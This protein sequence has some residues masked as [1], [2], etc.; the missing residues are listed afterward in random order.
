MKKST[1]CLLVMR[2]QRNK[3]DTLVAVETL[4]KD[5][6]KF[7]DTSFHWRHDVGLATAHLASGTVMFHSCRH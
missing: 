2:R 6:A 3:K 1:W 4:Q 5:K 7:Q